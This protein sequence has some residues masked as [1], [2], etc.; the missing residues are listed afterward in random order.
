LKEEV[1]RKLN[2]GRL[3]DETMFSTAGYYWVSRKKA[4]E[5]IVKQSKLAY[6]QTARI[7]HRNK[8]NKQRVAKNHE[9]PRNCS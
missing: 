6:F 5:N 4:E 1:G 3:P 2:E 7:L 8:G 9:A